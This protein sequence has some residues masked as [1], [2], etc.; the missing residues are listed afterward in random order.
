M[1]FEV[2]K[3]AARNILRNQRRSFVTLLAICIGVALIIVLDGFMGAFLN[4][5]IS[6]VVEGRTGALQVHRVGYAQNAYTDPLA[7]RF[8]YSQ[9]MVS[10]ITGIEGVKAV[11]GRITFSGL[12]TNGRSQ[13]L[14]VASAADLNTEDKV[15]P[16][17]TIQLESG[18]KLLQGDTDSVLLGGELAQSLQV[19]PQGTKL[20]DGWLSFVTLSANGPQGRSNSVD[21]KVKGVTRSVFSFE[22]KRV[23]SVPLSLAQKLLSMDNEVTELAISVDSLENLSSVVEN[24]KSAVGSEY[25]VQDWKELQPFIRDVLTRQKFILGI[26]AAT[27]FVMVLFGITNTMLMCVFERVREIGTL[28]AIG[29]RTQTVMKMFIWEA[30]ILGVLG[31]VIGAI[32]GAAIVALFGKIG[33]QLPPNSPFGD[34]TMNPLLTFRIVGLS[35][36]FAIVASVISSIIPARKAS[37]LNP[38]DALRSN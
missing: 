2:V 17:A 23:L 29:F 12:I 33:I 1:K 35:V 38:V 32:F 27:L 5:M 37:A 28:M 31:G 24:V 11:S 25:E 22:N 30:A 26:V 15:T 13:T 18:S 36:V 20:Q 4:L 3:L 10:K 8:P 16:Q 9:E 6:S 14:F 34:R 7:Y 21:V 19:A